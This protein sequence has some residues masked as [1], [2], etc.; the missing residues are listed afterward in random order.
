MTPPPVL[1]GLQLESLAQDQTIGHS[2]MKHLIFAA[3]L[4]A[5]LWSGAAAQAQDTWVQV[6]AQPTLSEAEARARA[7]SDAFPNVQG[8]RLPSGW[9]AIVLGPFSTDEAQRQLDLLRN[10]RLIPADSF[11]PTQPDFG[12]R[13]WPVGAPTS[14]P[15]TADSAPTATL[16]TAAPVLADVETPEQA[17]AAENALT[18]DQRMDL[19]RAL[20]FY[21]VYAGKIDG[22][23]GKGTRA[24]MADWQGRNGFEP[25]GIL[26]TAQRA[27]LIDGWTGERAALGLEPVSEPEAGIAMD[28]PLGL[29]EFAGY[30]PPFVTYGPKEGSG[31]QLLL[32]SRRGEGKDLAALYDRMLAMS[33]IPIEGERSLQ[34]ASFTITGEGNGVSAYAMARMESGLIKGF[35]LIGPTADSAR[36]LR[37]IEQ[38]LASFT[39]LAGKV[40][41]ANLGEPS[42]T[43]T[44][45]L[46]K[47]LEPRR[48]ALSRSG[49]FISAAGAVLTTTEVLQSCTQITLDGRHAA[50]VAYQDDLLGIAIL[51]PDMVLAPR[52]VAELAPALPRLDSD[53]LM[54]GYSYE[55]K[56]SA[57]VISSGTFSEA[58]G[59]NGEQDIARLTLQTLPGDVGGAVLDSTGAMI[60]LLAPRKDEAGRELPK[61][62][63]FILQGSA[64]AAALQDKAAVPALATTTATLATEELAQRARDMTVLVS[65][66]K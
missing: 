47:G 37:V 14:E 50:R 5:L 21:G 17:R 66:W 42:S 63:S 15:A 6:E 23:F 7:Y 49:V 39:P 9:Y 4:I 29:V 59:L 35:A 46:L 24:S 12:Q 54:A 40:L 18:S 2:S 1:L 25:T 53:V 27:A 22:S 3:T 28:L 34:A 38:M 13:F 16:T 43:P 10:E 33:A 32:I 31:Y 55:D 20:Q 64:I 57:P 45:A 41:D 44:A 60:G 61:D 65:C 30:Q 48:P 8:Y 56:L 26:T 36:R 52:A 51:E 58:S 19:Q 11:V 62:V